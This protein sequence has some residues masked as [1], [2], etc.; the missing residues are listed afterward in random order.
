MSVESENAK[1][2]VEEIIEKCVKC[3]LCKGLCPVFKIIREESISPRGKTI[4]LDKKIYE[5]ILYDCSL[6]KACEETCPLGLKLCE[7]FRKARIVLVEEGKT[8][9]ENK[10]MIENIRKEG[11][12][13]GK[14]AGKSKKLYCC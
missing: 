14:E 12:P 10:E 1:Q 9:D 7:A 8:T 6:C 11:N 4:M 3:G 13:F 5:K 2:Q